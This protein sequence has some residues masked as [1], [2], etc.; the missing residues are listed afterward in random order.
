MEWTE[1]FANKERQEVLD[2]WGIRYQVDQDLNLGFY[3]L[4]DM[5]R[6]EKLFKQALVD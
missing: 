2:E 5:R 6:A 1:I 4:R 3:S